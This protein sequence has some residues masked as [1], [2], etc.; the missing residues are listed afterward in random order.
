MK[1]ES[2]PAIQIVFLILIVSKV[3]FVSGVTQLSIID[4][5]TDGK[6]S[7]IIDL[8]DS[9]IPPDPPFT[10]GVSNLASDGFTS[11]VMLG[12]EREFGFRIVLANPGSEFVTTIADGTWSI[13]S[14]PNGI[15]QVELQYDGED[16]GSLGLDVTGLVGLG[17]GGK[18]YD[19][20]IGGLAEGIQI[21][22]QTNIDFAFTLLII[23]PNGVTCITNQIV[24]S[25]SSNIS[26]LIPFAVILGACDFS[27]VG[28]I[29][30]NFGFVPEAEFFM[31]SITTYTTQPFLFKRPSMC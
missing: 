16:G 15:V 9:S 18:G 29:E 27:N 3:V 23:S 31:H 8:G 1:G 5:F 12:G 30:L 20:T 2:L 10:Q 19:L 6:V 11:S 14:P 25:D 24:T 26:I 13:Y 21:I 22:L 7:L 28:A 4:D 17:E